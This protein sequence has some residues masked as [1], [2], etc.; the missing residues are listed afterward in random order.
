MFRICLPCN[1]CAVREALDDA[2]AFLERQSIEPETLTACKLALVEACNNAIVY[3]DTEGSRL[4]VEIQIACDDAWCELR[5]LD[6]TPGFDLPE[7][8]ELPDPDVERGRGVFI[9]HSLMDKIIYCREPCGNRLIMRKKR[10]QL[11][12]NR[13]L[14]T[15]PAQA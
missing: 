11:S 8:P 14:A 4:P 3:A 2:C 12:K 1:L 7:K 5:V 13:S 15:P 6:H 9:I 10:G